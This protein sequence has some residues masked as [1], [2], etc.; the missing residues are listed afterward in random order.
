MNQGSMAGSC[1][2]HTRASQTTCNLMMQMMIWSLNL[3]IDDDER[4]WTEGRSSVNK[5]LCYLMHQILRMYKAS[6]KSLAIGCAIRARRSLTPNRQMNFI[7]PFILPP[8]AVH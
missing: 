2:F 4:Q 7:Q 6:F 5:P 8:V 3:P 1:H